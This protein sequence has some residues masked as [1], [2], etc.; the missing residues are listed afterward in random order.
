MQQIKGHQGDVQFAQITTLPEGAKKV[1]Q[2]PL[3]LGEHSGHM[4]VLTG[5]VEL[6]ELDGKMFAAVGSDGARLQHVHE[7][8]FSAKCYTSTQELP[9]ADH[10]SHLLS[11]GVYEFHIQN[12]YNPYSKMMEQVVD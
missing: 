11:A 1:E 7:S 2:K 5:D 9:I 8:N 6:F 10:G 12:A 4:H 3:V